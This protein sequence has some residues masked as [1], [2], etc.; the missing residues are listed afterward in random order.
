[1]N[2]IKLNDT[3]YVLLKNGE[4]V[5]GLDVRYDQSSVIDLFDSGFVLE[6]G[7]RFVS[8]TELPLELQERYRMHGCPGQL[9]I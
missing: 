8:M 3:D 9:L 4:P 6:E 2:T 5:E 7:E 1:M